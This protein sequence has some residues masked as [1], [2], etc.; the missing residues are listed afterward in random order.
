MSSTIWCSCCGKPLD[1]ICHRHDHLCFHAPMFMKIF[2][3]VLHWIYLRKFPS[4]K[5]LLPSLPC[6]VCVSEHLFLNLINIL[7]KH[8]NASMATPGITALGPWLGSDISAEPSTRV[9][10]LYTANCTFITLCVCLCMSVCYCVYVY[11]LLWLWFHRSAV[12]SRHSQ[13]CGLRV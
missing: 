1:G 13:C 10:K 2:K 5:M 3:S 7:L 4:G 11:V 8:D 9:Q 12:R 6:G